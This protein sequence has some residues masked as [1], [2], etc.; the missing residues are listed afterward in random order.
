MASYTEPR[1]YAYKAAAAMAAFVAV[2]KGADQDHVAICSAASDKSIG[3]IQNAPTAADG[4]AEVAL[5]GGGAKAKLGA[6]GAAVGDKLV[7]DA[8]GALVVSTS[9]A[10]RS[11]ATANQDGVEGD[12]I[13][14]E[15]SSEII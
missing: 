5:P 7:P 10:A 11:I 6:G 14:V 13:A 15:V 9:N 2:K 1:I 4:V 3:I 8:N 12:V